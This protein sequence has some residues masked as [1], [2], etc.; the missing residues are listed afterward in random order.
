MV[1]ITVD[2]TQEEGKELRFWTPWWKKSCSLG[3]TSR[4]QTEVEVCDH[5][6]HLTGILMRPT[7]IIR[8][9]W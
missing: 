4:W 3:Q 8:F 1:L 2:K 7:A 5:Q 6:C 9:I